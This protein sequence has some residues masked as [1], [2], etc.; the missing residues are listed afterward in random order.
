MLKCKSCG[1]GVSQ[2]RAMVPPLAVM[3]REL[4]HAAQPVD[5]PSFVHC[6]DCAVAGSYRYQ[7]TRDRLIRGGGIWELQTRIL[8]GSFEP[9]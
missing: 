1:S 9:F 2:K 4:R 7:T 3:E 6:T 5:L 8:S